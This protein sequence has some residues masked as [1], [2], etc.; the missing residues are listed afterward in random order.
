MPIIVW[1]LLLVIQADSGATAR[2]YDMPDEATCE[3]AAASRH[4]AA[5]R[6]IGV[7]DVGTLCIKSEFSP[8]IKPRA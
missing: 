4:D 7:V 8:L 6:A 5:K 1:T 2:A 3:Q